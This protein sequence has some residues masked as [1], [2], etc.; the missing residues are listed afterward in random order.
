MA[1]R[2][3]KVAFFL[4]TQS[5]IKDYKYKVYYLQ[6]IYQQFAN[7]YNSNH[8]IF[9]KSKCHQK[10]KIKIYQN[11][12]VRE[13]LFIDGQIHHIFIHFKLAYIKM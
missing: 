5:I 3:K 4:A 13:L 12:D 9:Q 1:M 10:I 2:I 7:M 11:K 8:A 6:N